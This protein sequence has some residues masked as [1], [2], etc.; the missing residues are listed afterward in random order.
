MSGR[1]IIPNEKTNSAR[2]A[3]LKKFVSKIEIGATRIAIKIVRANEITTKISGG[4]IK[5]LNDVIRALVKRDFL[6]AWMVTTC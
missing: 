1:K 6:P 3:V 4:N 5:P 2:E